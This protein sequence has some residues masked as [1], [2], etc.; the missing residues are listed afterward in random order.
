MNDTELNI[1]NK[2]VKEGRE[3]SEP[4]RKT[5]D[6]MNQITT[7]VEV[8]KND[9]KHIKESLDTHIQDQR[10]HE[11]KVESRL[12]E[13]NKL[14]AE[15]FEASQKTMLDFISSA[16]QKYADNEQFLFWRNL[17]VVGIFLSIAVGVIGIVVDK[18]LHP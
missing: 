4:S 11:S 8:M 15:R 5:L 13:S 2:G 3:H 17:L 12:D 9:M 6:F 16:D 7:Q 10:T 18:V 14:L 1:F